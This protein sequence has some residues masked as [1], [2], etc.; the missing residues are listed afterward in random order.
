MRARGLDGAAGSVVGSGVLGRFRPFRVG[1]S[2]A[3]GAWCSH[4]SDILAA[5]ERRPATRAA[6]EGVRLN[7]LAATDLVHGLA[8]D[9]GAE[10][11]RSDG[12]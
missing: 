6:A 12:Q 8:E 11:Q 1:M 7:Q 9:S 5:T 4:H 10:P 2:L 3:L